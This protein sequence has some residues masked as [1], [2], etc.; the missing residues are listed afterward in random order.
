[1]VKFKNG[2][3]ELFFRNVSIGKLQAM[4]G[5]KA[6]A[7]MAIFGLIRGI[8]ENPKTK[9]FLDA[10][11]AIVKEFKKANDEKIEALKKEK[12]EL[13]GKGDKVQNIHGSRDYLER[14]DREI[15]ALSK[16][17]LRLDDPRVKELFELDS[18]VEIEKIE[19]DVSTVPDTF[20]PE[21]ML[22]TGMFINY[23]NSANK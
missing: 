10:K 3:L 23:I 6:A 15:D 5:L 16:A 12:A 20:T 2:D 1:M 9:A 19:L 8:G 18:G 11:E 14:I 4:T 21:D 7:R 17:E 13:Q 22:R